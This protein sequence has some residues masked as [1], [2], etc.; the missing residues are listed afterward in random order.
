[1]KNMTV[2]R[3]LLIGIV[4]VLLVVAGLVYYFTMIYEAPFPETPEKRV[5]LLEDAEITKIY[6][7]N[8][9]DGSLEITRN[10]TYEE[11]NILPSTEI[12]DQDGNRIT[13]KEL[14]EGQHIA[15]VVENE[16]QYEW[17]RFVKCYQVFAR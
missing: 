5:L 4:V 11:I 15:A 10:E 2:K 17:H 12:Y 3:W 6:M 14:S 16:V 13:L 7:A 9:Y 1:M 8:A